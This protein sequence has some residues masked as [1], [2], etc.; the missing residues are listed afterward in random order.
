MKFKKPID[1]KL[2]YNLNL[3]LKFTKI[4]LSDLLNPSVTWLQTHSEAENLVDIRRRLDSGTPISTN[5]AKKVWKNHL[6]YFAQSYAFCQASYEEAL[7]G[8]L[9]VE[10]QFA[11]SAL[12]RHGHSVPGPIYC[13]LVDIHA[14]ALRAHIKTVAAKMPEGRWVR[15]LDWRSPFS[16]F[17]KGYRITYPEYLKLVAA[18]RSLRAL[19]YPPV[20]PVPTPDGW[21]I[22]R[23]DNEI[24][25]RNDNE[26]SC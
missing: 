23:R 7:E 6:L 21:N 12:A 24:E 14:R 20:Q 19:G 25:H 3:S 22:Y 11:C 26:N 1:G 9:V 15:A 13:W 2:L 16:V 8:S 5:V 17:G 10:N 18:Y 4:L